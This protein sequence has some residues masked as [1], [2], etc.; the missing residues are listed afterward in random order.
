M[1]IKL[2]NEFLLIYILVILFIIV[3]TF[4]PL[5]VLRIIFG[6]PFILFFPGYV[7]IAA[8]FPR[9]STL[10]VIERVALSFGLSVIVTAVLVLIL[11]Y[12]PLGIKLYPV[13]IS[14]TIFIMITSAFAWYRRYRLAEKGFAISFNLRLPC[15]EAKSLVDRFLLII[16]IMAILGALGGA[17]YAVATFR[18]EES[19]TKFYV[20]G[21]EGEV[22]GYPVEL[23]AGEEGEVIVVIINNENETVDYR[24]EVRIDGERNTEVRPITLMPD[25]KWEE[26]VGFTPVKAGDNLKVEFL[27]YKNGDNEPFQNPLHLW[28]NVKE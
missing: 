23:K 5:N 10:D 25:D 11:N 18:A 28:V 22:G 12:T 17:G 27:L 8:I 19:F 7:L 13:L 3:I 21:P 24:L 14:L 20:L 1:S 6:L 26:A 15:W 16:L 4:L 9:K 2:K